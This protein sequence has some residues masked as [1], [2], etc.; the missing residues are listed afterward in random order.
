MNHDTYRSIKVR[1]ACIVPNIRTNIPT[2]FSHIS[3]FL[4]RELISFSTLSPNV[5]VY[6]V[7]PPLFALMIADMNSNSIGW[8]AQWLILDVS[9]VYKGSRC[10]RNELCLGP[11]LYLSI[12]PCTALPLTRSFLS[13]LTGLHRFALPFFILRSYQF[14]S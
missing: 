3:C 8:E 1:P 7:Y 4:A 2:H 6:A 10:V 5:F 13:S 11:C 12:D 14:L 9:R